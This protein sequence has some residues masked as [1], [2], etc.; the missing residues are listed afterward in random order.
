MSTAAAARLRQVSERD[1][2]ASVIDFCKL[3]GLDAFH[4]LV[5]RGM[6]PGWP[7]LTIIGTRVLFREL[8]SEIGGLSTEQ[9]RVGARLRAAGADWACWRPRDLHSGR[10][11]RELRLLCSHPTLFGSQEDGDGA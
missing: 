3:L 4:P 5:S 1:F 2:Q 9:R 6:A 11:E 8:K 10:V 7:D